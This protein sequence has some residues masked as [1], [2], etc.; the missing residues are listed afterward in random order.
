MNIEVI[1][2]K[3]QSHNKLSKLKLGNIT[4]SGWIKEQLKREAKGMGGNLD[5][6]EPNMLR[7]PF[8]SRKHEEKLDKEVAVSWCSE[9]SSIYWTGLVQLA[10][11]LNDG[12]LKEKAGAWVNS[13]LSNQ[14]ESGYIGSYKETDNRNEDY[15]ALGVSGVVNALLLYYEATKEEKVLE[16]CHKGLLWVV[17]EWD[18]YKKDYG[19]PEIIGPMSIVYLYT[20]DERLLNWAQKYM[21]W[22]NEN[23]NYPTDINSFLSEKLDYNSMHA[24]QLGSLSIVPAILYCVNGNKRYLE[25]SENVIQKIT[26]RC[27]QRTGAPSSNFEYLSPIGSICETEYCDFAVYSNTFSWLAM[28]TGE[29]RY[30][31][32]IEKIVFN[33]AQGG[34][35]KDEKAIAY[36]TSPNQV[37]ATQ[38]SSTFGPNP[39]MEVYAP[40]YNVA[41]C[42]ANS[43]R[44]IPEYVR[45]MCMRDQEGNLYFTC[46]GPCNV[47]IDTDDNEKIEI[48][49]VTKYPFE[50][51]IELKIHISNPVS[52]TMNLR[53][54]EWC[55]DVSIKINGKE[56]SGE[57]I[58]GKYFPINRLWKNGDIISI[59]FNMGVKVIRVDDSCFSNKR[60]IAI[61]RGPL[62]FSLPINEK[63]KEIE[64]KPLTKLPK[65]WSW[66]E[67]SPADI[68]RTL[69]GWEMY[70]RYREFTWNYALDLKKL[71][72]DSNIEI[73]YEENEE[74]PWEKSPVKIKVPA[75]KLK[76]GYPPYPIKTLEVYENPIET[77]EQVEM[78]ELIPYGCTAL[79]ISYFPISKE[80]S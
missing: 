10:F 62:L 53:I 55:E 40:V 38:F 33:G 74:Y 61:E 1:S 59:V 67:V 72:V 64:G 52:L 22:L 51:N 26:N 2:Q 66:Y 35:K 68:K 4:A 20:E 12:K 57:K 46:Y 48:D 75:R 29:A 15:N 65:G 71:S 41:C 19:G 23:S 78:I 50:D 14:E 13:V 44:V 16:A 42:P 34:R 63:W 69:M 25:S 17:K 9:I 27:M 70:D 56:I 8:I 31:D 28:I 58:R 37:Y 3:V 6:L 32:L 54:P 60:P 39:D 18:Y 24:V 49:E 79:R 11:T 76:Y 45:S 5:V 21:D 43:V 7:E 73:V 36:M 80:G 47:T 77:N 30:G